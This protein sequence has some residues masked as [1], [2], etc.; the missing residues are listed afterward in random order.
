MLKRF[1]AVAALLVS[2]S[3]AVPAQAGTFMFKYDG[4]GV[5]G[6]VTLTY[7]ANPNTGVIPGT[8]SP[9]LVDPI[10]SYIVTG[11]SGS[12]VNNNI[13]LTTT[14]TGVVPS[15]PGLPEPTNLYAPASFGFFNVASGIPKPN[16]EL[17][18]GFSYDNLFYPGGAPQSSS[19]YPFGGG[20]LDIYGLVFETSGGVWVNFWSNGDFG[21]GATYGA[22]VTDGRTVLDYTRGDVLAQAV[23]EPA[24]WAL[25]IAGFGLV[26]TALRRRRSVVVSFA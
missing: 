11:A 2:T 6:Q 7:A 21:G 25:M 24:S 13:G 17:A 10:G 1:G 12:F 16:G 20:F 3:L 14:I 26:G 8:D 18:P 15:N 5:S 23:P 4:S 22:G 19:D 9:N